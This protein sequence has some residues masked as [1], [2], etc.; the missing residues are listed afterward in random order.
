MTGAAQSLKFSQPVVSRLIHDR[1]S[2]PAPSCLRTEGNHLV[3]MPQ[4]RLLLVQV[5]HFAY[6]RDGLPSAFYDVP[7]VS[8]PFNR[9]Q[10][11]DALGQLI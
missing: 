10:L 3:P 7:M 9:Q 5:D 6:G 4:A 2:T 11:P 8:E 1:R